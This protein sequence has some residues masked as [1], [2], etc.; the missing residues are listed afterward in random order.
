MLYGGLPFLVNLKKEDSIIFECLKNIYNTIV[1]RVVVYRHGISNIFFLEQ[2]IIFL[3][4]IQVRFFRL[5][6]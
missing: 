6:A 4:I 2:L 5:K 1:L 3:Q